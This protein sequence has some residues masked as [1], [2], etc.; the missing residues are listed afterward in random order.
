MQFALSVFVCR[1][2]GDGSRCLRFEKLQDALSTEHIGLCYLRWLNRS[3]LTMDIAVCVTFYIFTLCAHALIA[4][5]L[6]ERTLRN[7]PEGHSA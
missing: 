6:K 1:D 2:N 5:S 3:S 7:C 4:S